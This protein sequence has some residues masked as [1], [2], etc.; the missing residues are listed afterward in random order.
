MQVTSK[1]HLHASCGATELDVEM[2]GRCTN[3]IRSC[4]F[5]LCNITLETEVEQY[6]ERPGCPKRE[7]LH[8]LRRTIFGHAEKNRFS[9]GGPVLWFVYPILKSNLL[10]KL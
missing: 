8:V 4:S 10:N 9:P 6:L 1:T 7:A 3:V 5:H 2:D